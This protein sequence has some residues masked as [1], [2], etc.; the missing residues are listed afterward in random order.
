MFNFIGTIISRITD[1]SNTTDSNIRDFETY[2][3]RV[4]AI[5][6]DRNI[7]AHVLTVPGFYSI[8]NIGSQVVI[9]EI[10]QEGG[11]EHIILGMVQPRQIQEPEKEQPLLRVRTNELVADSGELGKEITISSTTR[12]LKLGEIVDYVFDKKYTITGENK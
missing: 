12:A 4:P 5:A 2:E 11:V 10:Q 6:T 9:A 1:I 7:E 8:Y 3:V